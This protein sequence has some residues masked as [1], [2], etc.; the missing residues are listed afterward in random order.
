MTT[1]ICNSI[2]KLEATIENLHGSRKD[3]TMSIGQAMSQ[4]NV[5]VKRANEVSMPYLA[6][7]VSNEHLYMCGVC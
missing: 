2:P 7:R 5:C 6:T 4:N 3:P 1:R